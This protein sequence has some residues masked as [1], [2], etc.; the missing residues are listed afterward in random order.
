M[1]TDA[2]LGERSQV[3]VV[4]PSRRPIVL[5]RESVA[6]ACVRC[7]QDAPYQARQQ[8]RGRRTGERRGSAAELVEQERARACGVGDVEDIGPRRAAL[9]GLSRLDAGEGHAV[10]STAM[11]T[12]SRMWGVRSRRFRPDD[13]GV[14]RYASTMTT[15]SGLARRRR[16]R[17]A[18]VALDGGRASRPRRDPTFCASRRTKARG[19]TASGA[20]G[21]RSTTTSTRTE[22]AGYSWAAS[23]AGVPSQGPGSLVTST[24]TTV[25]GVRR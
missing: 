15:A 21:P 24:A 6:D 2:A 7:D 23:G 20:S 1:R 12:S 9:I 25:G 14:R 10:W 8:G 18:N 16:G 22:S 4:D 3:A 19:I 5:R 17:T 11:P 13:A